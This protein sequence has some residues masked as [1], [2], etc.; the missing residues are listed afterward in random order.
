MDEGPAI[1][2][3]K[4]GFHHFEAAM[5]AG[6]HEFIFSFEK[7]KNSCNNSQRFNGG[8]KQRPQTSTPKVPRHGSLEA[9]LRRGLH[10]SQIIQRNCPANS[11]VHH[12]PQHLCRPHQA[13]HQANDKQ[14][15]KGE[16]Q[17]SNHGKTTQR[18]PHEPDGE[19]PVRGLIQI[20]ELGCG[21]ERFLDNLGRESDSRSDPA[22]VETVSDSE[23][24]QGDADA[25]GGGHGEAE[26]EDSSSKGEDKAAPEYESD[27]ESRPLT[28]GSL[29]RPGEKDADYSRALDLG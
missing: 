17:G 12:I 6:E 18:H 27:H 4:D 25:V 1:A 22:G 7:I 26:E 16:I 19:K 29:P 5:S 20:G 21:F 2:T 23:A 28:E 9:E 15:R 11:Q 10:P 13:Q 8:H 14:R 3:A 24:N